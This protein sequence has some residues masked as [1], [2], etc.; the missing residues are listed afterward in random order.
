MKMK[1]RKLIRLITT[2]IVSFFLLCFVIVAG[3]VIYKGSLS[4]G[5]RFYD[6]ISIFQKLDSYATD[7]PVPADEILGDTPTEASY[8][9][10]V[11]YEGKTYRIKAYVFDGAD[12]SF[13]YFFRYTG[14]TDMDMRPW[15]QTMQFSKERAYYI[16]YNLGY[17]YVIEGDNTDHFYKFVNFVNQ[18]FPLGM[19]DVYVRPIDTADTGAESNPIDTAGVPAESVTD[20]P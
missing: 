13:D 16:A 11:K 8:I 1:K 3:I 20:A 18:D 14:A 9:K 10:T 15:S 4:V 12:T 6:D 7:E 5:I 2:G 17:L 19:E